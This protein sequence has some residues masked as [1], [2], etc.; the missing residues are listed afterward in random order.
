[1]INVDIL[2]RKRAVVKRGAH[3]IAMTIAASTLAG[4]AVGLPGYSSGNSGITTASTPP[5]RRN[6]FALGAP[7]AAY[8]QR[9]ESLATR[10][11]TRTA[12]VPQAARSPARFRAPVKRRWQWSEPRRGSK[13][14]TV[15]RGQSLSSIALE[16]RVAISE[17]M[18]ANRLR[19]PSIEPGQRLLV[20]LTR[21]ERAATGRSRQAVA[22]YSR[23]T[24]Y[25]AVPARA[26]SWNS[27]RPPLVAAQYQDRAYTKRP[28]LFERSNEPLPRNRQLTRG[29]QTAAA[30]RR[31]SRM[32][33]SGRSYK[34]Q[35][36][37]TLY[38]I[39]RRTGVSPK[40]LARHNA[41]A[42]PS[43]LP[44]GTMLSIPR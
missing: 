43:N 7:P 13:V 21:Y 24:T 23:R 31:R 17:L 40:R 33:Y 29:S 6:S 18:A 34:V 8:P 28:R 1:M 15:A 12:A 19:G 20:P 38:A 11:Y 39:S 30:A 32:A 4:C 14:I 10:P 36:G 22:A 44:I 2:G 26:N 5:Q 35:R 41:L 37:D 9:H 27:K 25:D 42:N 3:L 16:R